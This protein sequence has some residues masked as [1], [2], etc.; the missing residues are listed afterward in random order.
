[1]IR[2]SCY[3]PFYERHTQKKA[4][5]YKVNFKHF[6]IYYTPEIRILFSERMENDD[7]FVFKKARHTA[8]FLEDTFMSCVRFVIS[9]YTI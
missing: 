1:M 8:P 9:C 3:R 6:I 5:V 7:K 2:I 4:A